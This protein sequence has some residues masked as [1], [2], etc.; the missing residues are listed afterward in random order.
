[1]AKF[2]YRARTLA[3]LAVEG[4]LEADSERAVSAH[5]AGEGLYPVHIG[6]EASGA[7]RSPGRRKPRR[8]D[9]S[10]FIGELSELLEA[11]VPILDAIR[12]IRSHAAR[13]E[14]R[15]ML[16]SFDTALSEGGTLSSAMAGFPRVFSGVEVALIRAAEKGGFLAKVLGRMAGQRE[17]LAEVGSAVLTALAYPSVLFVVLISVITILLTFVVPKFDAL[18][19]DMGSHL[20]AATLV[21]ISGSHFIVS[22]WYVIALALVAA[23]I[24]A[25]NLVTREK[26][27]RRA[28]NAILQTPFVSDVVVRFAASRFARSLELMLEGGVPL[29]DALGMAGAT[30]GLYGFKEQI[31]AALVKVRDGSR[32]ADALKGAGF[33]N[34]SHIEMLAVA[35]KAGDLPGALSRIAEKA[36]KATNMAIKRALAV[37]EPGLIVI[38]AVVVGYVVLSLLV[39]IFTISAAVR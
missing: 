34:S 11:G 3:G 35:E 20:P 1:M 33:L 6:A 12:S 18:F 8:A 30:T 22:Y 4:V 25:V 13:R 36:D 23:C 29:S 16:D 15:A 37:L 9:V 38:M 21:L 2:T 27:R 19:S 28:E 26:W 5:L 10:Q 17:Y 24:A 7:S 31:E 32:V 39:P 14:M